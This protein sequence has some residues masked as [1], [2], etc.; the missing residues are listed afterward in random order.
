MK[1]ICILF[2]FPLLL[3][4]VTGCEES[5]TD[6]QIHSDELEIRSNNNS[7]SQMTREPFNETVWNDCT[8]EYVDLTGIFKS[9]VHLNVDGSGIPHINSKTGFSNT[10]GVGQTTGLKY[11]LVGNGSE[12]NVDLCIGDRNVNIHCNPVLCADGV[13]IFTGVVRQRLVSQSN[14]DDLVISAFFH[15][16][17][18][19]G[20]IP[21]VKQELIQLECI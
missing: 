12:C 6:S 1:K 20:D 14:A 8:G 18:I 7:Q 2:L 4:V 3:L 19:A 13:V 16:T 9:M 11:R 17:Y 21:V 15:I 5:L 10:S